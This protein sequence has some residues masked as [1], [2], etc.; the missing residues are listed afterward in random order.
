MCGFGALI[1]PHRPGRRPPLRYTPH[2]QHTSEMSRL[3]PNSQSKHRF[4]SPITIRGPGPRT[5]GS[6][7]SVVGYEDF[8]LRTTAHGLYTGDWK[9]PYCNTCGNTCK[10]ANG[11][12]YVR[13]WENH[14]FLLSLRVH[15]VVHSG[16]KL[17][18][19]ASI[20]PTHPPPRRP[21]GRPPAPDGRARPERESRISQ[22]LVEAR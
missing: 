6:A 16:T 14:E 8:F 2:R 3:T 13:V 1:V 15:L 10:G 5:R 20:P 21:L 9:P 4:I 22:R 18:R 11:N 7:C 17:S 12:N 19:E